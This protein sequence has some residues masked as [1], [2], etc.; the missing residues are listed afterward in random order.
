MNKFQSSLSGKVGILTGGTSGFGYA[1]TRA[2]LARG[3]KIAVFSVDQLSEEARVELEAVGKGEFEYYTKDIMTQGASEEIVAQTIERFGTLDFVIANAG[4]AIRFEEPFLELSP[5][6]LVKSFRTQFEVFPIALATLVQAA[7]KVMA[8]RYEAVKADALGHRPDS[9][10][11]VVTLS[12][13]SLC[14]LRD[15]LLAYAAAK[16]AALSV[17]QSLAAILGPKNIR[18]NGIAPGFANTAGPR[19]F[20]DRFP[21]IKADVEAKTHLKPSFVDPAAVTPAVLYLLTDNYVTGELIA[22]DGGFNIELKR[23]FQGDHGDHRP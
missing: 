9:G 22:L 15:D 6:K 4:F 16:R 20:Y 3:A 2:L 21:H 11:I 12:E 18:V 10:A 19:K 23:Y 8:P 17:M 5:E 14:P 1:I 7:A 13:A